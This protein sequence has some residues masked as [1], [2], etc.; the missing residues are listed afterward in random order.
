VG[1]K[2]KKKYCFNI[3]AFMKYW[4]IFG[5]VIAGSSVSLSLVL[6]INTLRERKPQILPIKGV[7]KI[8]TQEI[9]LEYAETIEQ[10]IK[11]LSYR[12][13]MLDNQGMLFIN[14]KP[15]TVSLW[16]LGVNQNLDMFF[17][18]NT[19][20]VT[21]AVL[22]AKPCHLKKFCTIYSGQANY[23]LELPSTSKKARF[24]VG[25]TLDIKPINLR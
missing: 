17:L 13:P 7:L 8:G 18:D 21:K 11:G 19:F 4:N 6:A 12:K 5:C 14:D 22:A 16:M 25:E 10:K 23:I 20:K 24:N 3:T 2:V 9:L 1:I 15:T